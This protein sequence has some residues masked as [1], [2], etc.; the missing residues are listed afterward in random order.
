MFDSLC[1]HVQIFCFP[2]HLS[3]A[4]FRFGGRHKLM[5]CVWM[6]GFWG[7]EISYSGKP[8]RAKQL[9]RVQNVFIVLRDQL[10]E[11]GLV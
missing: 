10:G 9:L 11:R 8:C 7:Q 1:F 6:M 4:Q 2:C 3:E 5:I